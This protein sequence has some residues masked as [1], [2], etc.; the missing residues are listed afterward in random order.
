MELWTEL[1]CCFPLKN[2]MC[3]GPSVSHTRV[4]QWPC[5]DSKDSYF[6]TTMLEDTQLDNANLPVVLLLIGM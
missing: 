2:F 3:Y 6:H 1:R 4:Y 5:Y